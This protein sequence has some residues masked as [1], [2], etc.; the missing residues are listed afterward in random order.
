MN[1]QYADQELLAAG[2]HDSDVRVRL[3]PQFYQLVC[4][5]IRAF[6]QLTIGQT[7]VFVGHRQTVWLHGCKPEKDINECLVGVVNQILTSADR[8]D[9]C[10]GEIVDQ[11]YASYVCS[12]CLCHG[13]GK[14]LERSEQTAHVSFT[15]ESIVEFKSNTIVAAFFFISTDRQ[16]HLGCIVS[17]INAVC[18]VS[19]LHSSI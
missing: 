5:S 18:I 9:V 3:N 2:Q 16:W 11:R 12:I 15:I 13:F 19:I 7:A 4:K 6:I 1:A 8:Q 10:S 17:K 14:V